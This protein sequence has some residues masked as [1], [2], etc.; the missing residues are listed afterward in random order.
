VLALVP[1]RGERDTKYTAGTV[2]VV[3]G[4]PGMTGAAVLAA[5]AALRA[6]AGYVTLAVPC[7]SLAVAETLALE[8]VKRGFDWGPGAVE[9]LRADAA[10]ADALALG[11][12]LGR[13]PEAHALVRA[14]LDGLDLPAVVDADALY[15]LDPVARTAP[16]VL[17]PHA[18]E[19]A[20]LLGEEPAWVGAHRLE[21]AR[22]AAERFG[23]V[24]LLKGAD[25]IVQAPGEPPLVC[26]L[27][28]PSLATAGTG[29][30]LTGVA[31]AFLAKGLD[32]RIAAASAAAAHG[33]AAASVPH[34]AG[35]VASDVAAALP[36]A[37]S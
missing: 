32:A 30:V 7:A 2:L 26:D 1:R 18:G 17:T 12:G 22:R 35:L 31:A 21:A 16:T 34:Q 19:L 9:A 20:R 10:R 23:A 4:S 3:G 36:V 6:D 27:G 33:A 28:P 8:P 15:G 13:T 5:T 29:D 37:L 14:L 25:T 11:P 24:V